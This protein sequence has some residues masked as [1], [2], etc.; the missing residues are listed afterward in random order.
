[1]QNIPRIY[2]N[3][4]IE[5]GK[6]TAVDKNIVHYL[7]HVMRRND[8]LVFNDGC[9]YNAMLSEDNKY[10]IIGEKTEH[11]DPGNNLKF[12]FA[13]IIKTD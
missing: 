2:I 12:Y 4:H 9:E 7:R 13:P 3:E 5:T 8:C 6:N 10:L 11:G 1:M